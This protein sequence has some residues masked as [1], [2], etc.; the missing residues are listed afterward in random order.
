MLTIRQNFL[1]TI[2]GGNPDRFVNQYEYMKLVGNPIVRG[3]A[4][5][6]PRGGTI[7]NDWGVTSAWPEHVVT[8]FP[9]HTPEMILL[10]D[11]TKWRDVLKIPDPHS[12]DDL[13]TKDHEKAMADVDRGEVFATAMIAPGIFERLHSMMS[14]TNCLASFL[15]EPEAM[16]E[17]I[18]RLAD[19]EIETARIVVERQ[20]PDAIFHHDDWGTQTRSFLSPADFEKFFLP[21]YKRIYGFWK[22]NG[23]E[24]IVH[25]TD[26][27]AANLVP[28]MIEMGIDV[29]Q[30]AV[31][32]NNIPELIRQYGG[33]ISF[34]GGLDN[35]KH[36]KEDW[37]VEALRRDL[38]DLVGKA[39]TKYLIPGLTMGEP[40]S[41]YPGV[42]AALSA[43][44][45]DL[46]KEYF[47]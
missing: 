37:S 27:Y 12:Y 15:E 40:G 10:K 22:Q 8:S 1:E 33:Q 24:I 35:G 19:W 16:L 39:G 21:A 32:E 17:L 44:I 29:Y 5:A 46:S 6:C 42:Y 20:H 13:W 38:R 26:S 3:R 14:M 7:V 18:D 47:K 30:G 31:S 28:Y 41:L 9:V 34:H 36:D 11:V 45:D 23:V 25:H 4:G 43:E 2:H